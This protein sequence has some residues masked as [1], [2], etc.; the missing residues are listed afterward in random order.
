MCLTKKKLNVWASTSFGKMLK[1]ARNKDN[2]TNSQKKHFCNLLKLRRNSGDFSSV[3]NMPVTGKISKGWTDL[4]IE[5]PIIQESL[6]ETMES[7]KD[8]NPAEYLFNYFLKCEEYYEGTNTD[9]DMGRALRNLPSYL[10][11]Y[12]TIELLNKMGIEAEIPSVEINAS[13]H[14]D[15]IGKFKGNDVYMWSYLKT[16]NS[17]EFLL[18]KIKTRGKI[19]KGLNIL[20][21]LQLNIDTVDLHDWLMP[22]EKYMESIRKALETD[23][24]DYLD[25]ASQSQLR[26]QITLFM[27]E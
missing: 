16:P 10:R 23:P 6:V 14:V 17:L 5:G 4:N 27:K 12:Y 9:Y 21:P 7:R 15:I 1:H 8:W 3:L 22:S 11:E 13:Y 2:L 25:V 18:K 24:V 20:L 19:M 26:R